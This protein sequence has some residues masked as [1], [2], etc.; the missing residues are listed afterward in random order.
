MTIIYIFIFI[1][2]SQGNVDDFKNTLNHWNF[3]KFVLLL[4]SS[5]ASMP[6]I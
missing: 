6:A 4:V 1:Q 3:E 5:L 2:T